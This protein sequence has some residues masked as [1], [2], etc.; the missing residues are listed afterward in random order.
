MPRA[1]A[2]EKRS[3]APTPRKRASVSIDPL[4]YIDFLCLMDHAA[5]VITDSGGI[6][7][8]TTC[9]GIRCVT[10]RENTE[11]P[12]TVQLGTNLLAGTS[13]D[14]IRLAIRKQLES[15]AVGS[16]P[17]TWDGKSAQRIIAVDFRGNRK[18]AVQGSQFDLNRGS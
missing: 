11:R 10:V 14:G 5:I 8:E 13:K 7:E 9:L 17:D 18:E 16:V 1:Q 12:I 15:I 4:G 6:Q 3:Q 2:R